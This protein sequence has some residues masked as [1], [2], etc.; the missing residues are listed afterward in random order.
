MRHIGMCPNLDFHEGKGYADGTAAAAP[1]PQQAR[2]V[3]STEVMPGATETMPNK[4]CTH[5]L[6]GPCDVSTLGSRTAPCEVNDVNELDDR[7]SD[8][9]ALNKSCRAA[10]TCFF[11]RG[12]TGASM[13]F[14]YEAGLTVMELKLLLQEK[15][16]VPLEAQRVLFQG[17]QLQD[18]WTLDMAGVQPDCSLVLLGRLR[19]GMPAAAVTASDPANSSRAASST[20]AIRDPLF[21]ADPWAR[22]RARAS[23]EQGGAKRQQGRQRKRNK[24]DHHKVVAALCDAVA[25]LA[26]R[27]TA[28]E[29]RPK[30]QEETD[31]AYGWHTMQVPRTESLS[32]EAGFFDFDALSESERDVAI[33][34]FFIGSAAQ[35][36]ASDSGSV[37]DS[38]P[39]EQRQDEAPL[40]DPPTMLAPGSRVVAHS[41][42]SQDLNGA[43]GTLQE[44]VGDRWRVAFDKH[45]GMLALKP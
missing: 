10:K 16:S 4:A 20:G 39:E 18:S 28:L 2:G 37:A 8:S 44:R 7:E 31:I 21:E 6:C 5:G 12:W 17:R 26:R 43:V 29:A 27:V 22:S 9:N 24:Q 1:R 45:P 36:E 14:A 42:V 13:T 34:A 19:G 40:D 38:R 3:V 35:S 33:P 32:L 30:R 25:S 41:L 23:A 11:V 15:T